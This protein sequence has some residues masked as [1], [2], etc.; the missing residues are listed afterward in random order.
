MRSK[1]DSVGTYSRVLCAAAA[2]S[3]YG[4][5]SSHDDDGGARPLLAAFNAVP[6]LG[7]ITFLREEEVWSALDFGVGTEFRSVDADQYDVN[8]DSRLPGDETTTCAGDVD[9]DDVKDD[10]EC[11]R[12]TSTSIN[13]LADHEYVVALL[14]HYGALE[15]HVYDKPMHKFDTSDDDGDAE[16]ENAEVQ[17]FHFSEVLGPLDVYLEPPGTNLSPVQARATLASGEEFHGF[18]DEGDYVIT[19]AAVGDPSTPVFTSETI[20]LDKQTRVAF[21]IR[22][23]AGDGTSQIKVSRFRDQGGTLLDRRVKT[24]LRFTHVAPEAGNV[25]VYAEA[26]YTQP[27]F[28]NVPFEQTSAYREVSSTALADFDLDITPAGNPGVLLAREQNVLTKGERATFFLWVTSTGHLDGLKVQDGF[29]RLATYAQ[30]R[31]INGAS[32]SLD[33]YVV[34]RGSNINTLSP[35]RTLIPGTSGGLQSFDPDAYDVAMT[36]AGT[37]SLVFGPLGVELSGGGIYTIV[38]IATGETTAADAALLDDFAN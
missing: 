5:D 12:L 8:F 3:A 31:L 33:F 15:V 2:L 7:T 19:L 10:E 11:T 21:A 35:T 23:G 32:G 4:C 26:D 36:Q 1:F 27:F 34:P 18:A 38:A 22:D 37:D 6:D 13:V 17:F 14:G 9:K 28:A 20:S 24:Q 29:R 30:L 25:D 16:D